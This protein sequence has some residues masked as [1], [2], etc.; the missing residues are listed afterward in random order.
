LIGAWGSTNNATVTLTIHDSASELLWKYDYNSSGSVG[1]SPEKLTDALMKNA[2][3]KFPY[4]K[5]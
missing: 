3:K 5:Y 2:S 1:S 4:G